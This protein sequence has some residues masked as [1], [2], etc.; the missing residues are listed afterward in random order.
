M[1]SHMPISRTGRSMKWSKFRQKS[2]GGWIF[3]RVGD[4]YVGLYSHL[5]YE[6]QTVGPDADQ[7]VIALGRQNIW[8][9]QLGR[10]S[11][12][13]EFTDFVEAV[14]QAS[15]EIAGLKVEFASPGNGIISFAWDGPFQ[16]DGEDVSLRDYPRWDNP[17]AQAEFDTRQILNRVRRSVVLSL[18][19]DKNL[20]QLE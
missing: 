10:K 16:V 4:G 19:F 1:P 14:S 3:G 6:W 5:P 9:T 15:P 11:V 12:D 8:I 13:G 2:G 17:Y 18:D 20:R 7:E